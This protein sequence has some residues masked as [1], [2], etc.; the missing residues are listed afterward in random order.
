MSLAG[1]SLALSQRVLEATRVASA[2][3]VE[4]EHAPARYV[5]TCHNG[6]QQGREHTSRPDLGRN[7]MGLAPRWTVQAPA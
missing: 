2:G 6:Q 4:S 1:R 5:P 3:Y 7:G